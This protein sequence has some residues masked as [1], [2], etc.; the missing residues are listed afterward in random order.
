MGVE[1]I[2]CRP[3]INF[4]IIDKDNDR[5]LVLE[6]FSYSPSKE[7]RDLMLELRQLLGRGGNYKN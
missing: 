1:M 3:F 4:A 6:G 7:K 2:L 5:V